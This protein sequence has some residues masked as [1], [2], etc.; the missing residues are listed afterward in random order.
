M[1]W[2]LKSPTSA[3]TPRCTLAMA[4][5]AGLFDSGVFGPEGNWG[6]MAGDWC[7]A[8]K[9]VSKCEQAPAAQLRHRVLFPADSMTRCIIHKLASH[10][11]RGEGSST[12]QDV[13]VQGIVVE[14]FGRNDVHH[15]ALGQE[16]NAQ[17][18]HVVELVA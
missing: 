12:G 1:E 11:H 7:S 13:L 14:I 16:L 15:L 10:G 4:A 18:F 8:G 3:N 9:R 6:D 17:R 5:G 2:N